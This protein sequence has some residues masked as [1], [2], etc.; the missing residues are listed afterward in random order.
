VPTN[1]S[2]INGFST[3]TT[4]LAAL[5]SGKISAVELLDLHLKRINKF[6][7]SL[8][9]IVILNEEQ[10]RRQAVAA[11]EAFARG[12]LLGRL[13]GLPVTVKDSI[14]I[15]GLP[16]TVGIAERAQAIALRNGPVAQRLLAAGAVLIGK[17]NVS[18][19]AGDWHSH[20]MLFGR[21]NNPWDL[22]H[23]PGGS[24]GGGAA[25]VA[26]G[27]T[28]LE[29]GGDIGG[30]IRIPAAFCGIYGHRPSETAV[31]RSGY[32]PGPSLPNPAMIM[33]VQGPLARSASDL[34]LGLDTIA[35]PEEGEDI[36][37]RL[38]LPPPRHRSLADFRVA[39]L[40]YASWLP[41]DDEIMASIDDLTFHL[42]RCGAKVAQ[43]QPE[44]FDLWQHEELYA[45]L[46]N[47]IAFFDLDDA[48][49]LQ[50]ESSAKQA[51]DLFSETEYP[52]LATNIAQYIQWLEER[53]KYRIRYRDFFR[54]WDIL[55]SPVTINLPFKHINI[56]V[57]FA[58]RTLHINDKTIPY[59]RMRVYPGIATLS[60]Q[61]ATAFPW[62]RSHTG[63]PI[64][65]QAVGPYLEDKTP[66]T[67]V[68][69]LEKEFGGALPPPEYLDDQ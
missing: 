22:N 68:A 19:H 38:T 8:N 18:P 55:L 28:P 69:L 50:L 42:R 53:E 29:F 31:P 5:H 48:V 63:L 49:R 67:F 13:H 54:E 3:A 58:L 10:A 9:A 26:A 40:P 57:P 56:N 21:T 44:G 1:T 27:L 66:L 62:G 15:Q 6:N 17:T 32:V 60:G 20:N 64:G 33:N 61:P 46:L 34:E 4:M 45:S 37:W 59:A 36:A 11:D 24:T 7:P 35:G 25:A 51:S 12:K 23:T 65:L 16:T 39:I 52:G 41:V 47:S 30:S 2:I 43:A 14:E